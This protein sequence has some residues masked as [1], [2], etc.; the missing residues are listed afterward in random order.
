M[1]GPP[2]GTMVW[3]LVLFKGDIDMDG[4]SQVLSRP[5]AAASRTLSGAV[6]G[7]RPLEEVCC[8]Q[9]AGVGTIVKKGIHKSPVKGPLASKD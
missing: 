9:V 6:F 3:P 5:A 7:L 2:G 8:C 1:A 4:F